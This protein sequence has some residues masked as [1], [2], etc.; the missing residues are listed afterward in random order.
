MFKI[1]HGFIGVSLNMNIWARDNNVV[2]DNN[3]RHDTLKSMECS[4][5][6]MV[7]SVLA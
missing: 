2:V 6:S 5:L 3:L 7:L 1:K 4:K